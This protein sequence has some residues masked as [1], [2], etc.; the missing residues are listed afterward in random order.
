[1]ISFTEENERC[2]EISMTI[3]KSFE[4][5]FYVM[6][7]KTWIPPGDFIMKIV[8]LHHHDNISCP[9]GW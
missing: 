4:M 3:R 1:M 8:I 6:F 2:N 5:K 7:K 9:N